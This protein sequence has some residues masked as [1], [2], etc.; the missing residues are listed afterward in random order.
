VDRV[1]LWIK[2]LAVVVPVATVL[3]GLSRPRVAADPP[4]SA[5]VLDPFADVAGTVAALHR[6]H[7][8]AECRLRAGVWE[9][10][11]PDAGRFDPSLIGAD[12]DQGRWLDVRRLAPLATIIDDRLALCVAKGF[13]GV[14]FSDLDGYRHATGFPLTAAD[15]ATF[16]RVVTDLAVRRRLTVAEDCAAAGGGAGSGGTSTT[17]GS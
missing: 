1:P 12:A 9:P 4:P 8:R 5:Q 3:S 7:T 16:N 10:D 6:Q 2:L 11:R 15:Q 17:S 14:R 13:D